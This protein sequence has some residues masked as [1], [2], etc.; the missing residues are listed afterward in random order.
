MIELTRKT[1]NRE[2]S[3]Y[4]T[5]V[6]KTEDLYFDYKK[7]Q[8]KLRKLKQS[9]DQEQGI[10]FKPNVKSSSNIVIKTSFKER[11]NKVLEYKKLLNELGNA[12]PRYNNKKYTSS[13]IEENNKRIVERLYERDLVKI[14]SKNLR[15]NERLQFET[16]ENNSKQQLQELY[17]TNPLSETEHL[18]FQIKNSDN[19]I[20]RL[21][22]MEDNEEDLDQY[23]Y[24]G[25]K[26]E[27]LNYSR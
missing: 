12:T 11:N 26:E 24:E 4:S 18:T 25:E 14:R 5:E 16:N 10:T 17:R 20:D 22:E 9:V 19:E 13:E 6:R 21:E 23:E 15:T 8:D 2:K 1:H 3:N 7:K 27:S